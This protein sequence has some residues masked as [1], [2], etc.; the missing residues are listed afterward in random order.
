MDKVEQTLGF[1][2]TAF[3]AVLRS[4]GET[5]IARALPWPELRGETALTT[6]WPE[7][8]AERAAQAWSIAF[9]LLHQAEE[10][11]VAQAR[12][13]AERAEALAADA[14]SFDQHFARLRREGVTAETLAR[15]LAD[16]RIEPV[17]TAHPTEAKRQ[18]VL[19]HHRALYRLIV[20]L[21]NTMWTPAERSALE[22]EVRAC[23]ERLWR[24]GE[25]YLEKPSVADE[26][27]NVLH[28]L[29]EVFP[30]AL[31]WVERRLAAAWRRAGLAE[32]AL[33]EAGPLAPLGF[34]SWVGGDRDG[35]PF[36][37]AATT[38]ETLVLFRREALE[39]IDRRLAE[40]AARS[41]LSD[42]LTAPPAEFRAWV[43]QRAAE[44]GEAGREALVRNPDELFRQA[45]NLMRAS[46]PPAEA[47][48]SPA[49]YTSPD[50]L[51]ADL[52]RL[53]AA[54]AAVG[55]DRLAR[56]DVA[57]LRRHLA[58]FG[59]HLAVLDVRQNSAFHDRAL[60]HLL[61]SAGVPDGA[62]F[63]RWDEPRRR[64]FLLDELAH[65]RPF[66]M[67][68]QPL[69]GEADDAVGVLAVLARH[70]R[71]RGV[72]GLGALIVSMTRGPADLFAVYALAR[73]AGLL[74]RD[75]D[76]PW[77]PLPVVP[78]FETID[79]LVRAPDILA[80]Y[81][82]EPLVQ[83][84]VARQAASAGRAELLQQVMI[85]YSDSGKDGGIVASFWALQRAQRALVEVARTR[86]VRLCFFHGRGGTIGRGAGPTHRF[87][88]ALPPGSVDGAL[89]LTEQGET[90]AQKYA[91]RVTAAHHLELL[92]AGTLTATLE[93]RRPPRPVP[94][95]LHGAMDRLADAS[96]ET[97]RALVAAPGFIRFFEQATPIDAIEQ[98]RIGSRPARRTGER[99][100]ADLRAIPWVFAWSQARFQLPGWF[101]L[102]SALEALGGADADA[103]AALV[104]AKSEADRWEPWHYLVSNAATAWATASPDVMRRYA[105]LVEEEDLR[106]TFLETVLAEHA[107]TG[108]MLEAIYGAP[109]ARVR[110]RTQRVID[111]RARALD[112]L[113]DHQIA[114]LRHWR[115]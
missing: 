93:G 106:R 29:T 1:L 8:R 50:A 41:S 109:L 76:G 39:L 24:T 18:S 71:A 40:L 48:P 7:T 45:V 111:R 74:Q 57:P 27:R 59:F 89:R 65:P 42:H 32:D 83:R 28:Y 19:H 95:V 113:H 51:D 91:N 37:T 102:G 25:I 115:R 33:A 82:D 64:A 75:V 86:G 12:R 84:S 110:A 105:A 58:T 30:T 35:H 55:A 21:E 68:G 49:A 14:G 9:Q 67:P 79:D 53:A 31:P 96:R 26:R 78:L 5:E 72:S 46:L 6:D 85:G 88:R 52:A 99:T 70:V 60:A 54:L 112:P 103:M 98:S 16:V 63:A 92:V 10:N 34:G 104:R 36:V 2:M 81:L 44:L 100:L 47:A 61:D 101:G 87:L 22:A 11:A 114:C 15:T 23:L 62:S 69:A 56:E 4:L 20:E 94:P 97:Y 90:I 77:L 66:V 73:E 107:R 13:D 80:A 43:E 17:L 3:A 108:R 38:A